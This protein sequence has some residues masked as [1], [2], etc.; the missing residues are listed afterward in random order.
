M[1]SDRDV[2]VLVTLRVSATPLSGPTDTPR[3][4]ASPSLS[5]GTGSGLRTIHDSPA[6]KSA[7][8]WAAPRMLMVR[9]RPPPRRAQRHRN[10]RIYPRIP[11]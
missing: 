8:L 9:P 4:H 2:Q 1:R 5:R 6:K 10:K 7:I 11:V 3:T